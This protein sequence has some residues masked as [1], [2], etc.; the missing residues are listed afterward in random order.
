M[1][2]HG[3]F[4]ESMFSIKLDSMEQSERQLTIKAMKEL[5]GKIHKMLLHEPMTLLFLAMQP[6]TQLASDC[7][8]LFLLMNL[9]SMHST[10]VIIK[11]LS[12]V[13]K[14]LNILRVFSI[15]M[16]PHNKESN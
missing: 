12:K 7:G 4:K 3:K 9:T 8:D 16:I 5:I 15:Q 10:V 11:K 13:G 2:T 14:G 1:E 6:S